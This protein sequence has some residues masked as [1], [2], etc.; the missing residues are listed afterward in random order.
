MAGLRTP[1][2]KPPVAFRRRHIFLFRLP[3]GTVSAA[4]HT[5]LACVHPPYRFS[6]T[7]S[8]FASFSASELPPIHTVYFVASIT[9]RL[10][11]L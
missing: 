11:T 4:H 3:A 10:S 7:T 1:P 5:R 9:G 8:K 2:K 6:A